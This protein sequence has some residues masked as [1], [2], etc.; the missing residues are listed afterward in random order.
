[1]SPP[2]QA[3][4]GLPQTVLCAFQKAFV[5]GG[6]RQQAGTGDQAWLAASCLGQGLTQSFFF[7][8][9]GKSGLRVSC[10]GLGKYG[11]PHEQGYGGKPAP[12]LIES[13]TENL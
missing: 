4:S 11:T 5:L 13:Y 10:L 1:M 6:S 9:L 7:R 8:N 3:S 12:P 2:Q